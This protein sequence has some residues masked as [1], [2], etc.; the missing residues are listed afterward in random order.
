MLQPPPPEPRFDSS[1]LNNAYHLR[2]FHIVV[3]Y[4]GN[5]TMDTANNEEAPN[6]WH[7][8][9]W[10]RSPSSVHCQTA[11][12]GPTPAS[13][14]TS[15]TLIRPA[16]SPPEKKDIPTFPRLKIP[17]LVLCFGHSWGEHLRF[18]LAWFLRCAALAGFG[19][20]KSVSP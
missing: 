3:N 9:Q 17:P 6:V 13:I 7:N 2:Y 12:P 19:S 18:T 14:L 8:I 16:G 15:E 1:Y 11:A 4:R 10:E 5:D 20:R